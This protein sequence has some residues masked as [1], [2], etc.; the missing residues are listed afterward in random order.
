M[1][2]YAVFHKNVYYQKYAKKKFAILP[3]IFIPGAI[4]KAHLIKISFNTAAFEHF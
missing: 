3:L 1:Y 4:K 2:L